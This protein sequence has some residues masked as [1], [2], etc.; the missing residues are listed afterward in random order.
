[1]SLSTCTIYRALRDGVRDSEAAYRDLRGCCNILDSLCPRWTIT[2][3]VAK[4]ANRL[5]ST[6]RMSGAQDPRGDAGQLPQDRPQSN[7]V[8]DQTD[9]EE[10]GVLSGAHPRLAPLSYDLNAGN[11]PLSSPSQLV[12]DGD[13]E[14]FPFEESYQ[15]SLEDGPDG[16]FYQF[17]SFFPW[18]FDYG[19]PNST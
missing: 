5:C 1:M 10:R 3:G 4:L 17:D 7:F 2:K 6:P 16:P 13:C 19:L 9:G 15:S 18:M 12:Q 8:T 11:L 14:L